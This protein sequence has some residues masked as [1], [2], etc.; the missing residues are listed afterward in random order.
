MTSNDNQQESRRRREFDVALGARMRHE[1]ERQGMTQNDLAVNL[2]LMHDI[3]WWHQTTVGKVESGDRPIRLEE[4]VAVADLLGVG[5]DDLAYG[6]ADA[7][8]RNQRI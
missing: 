6:R 5:L 7:A 8:A 4:A 1:R 3:D 2:I